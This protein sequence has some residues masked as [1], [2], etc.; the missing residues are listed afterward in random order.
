MK[1]RGIPVAVAS[2]NTRDPFYA[3]GDLDMLEVYREATRI[4][5]FDHPVGDWP[6]T[7]AATPASALG[8]KDCRHAEGRAARPISSSSRAGTGRSSCRGRNRDRIVIR[9]GRPIDTA[10]PDYPELDDLME[11]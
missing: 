8:L 11:A 10:L 1:A 3:Y 6:K 2:D 5:Q 4:L 9:N 7:V